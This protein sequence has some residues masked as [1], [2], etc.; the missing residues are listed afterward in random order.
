VQVFE[1]STGA[2][3]PTLALATG[4]GGR[5]SMRPKKDGSPALA[6]VNH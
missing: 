1:V 3:S 5:E 2:T 4:Q 6:W